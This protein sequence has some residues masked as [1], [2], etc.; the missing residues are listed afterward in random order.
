MPTVH[1]VSEVNLDLDKVLDGV[2]QLDLVE[3]EQFAFEVNN[4]VARR[5][6]PNL[7]QRQVEL[8]QQ[9]N[10]GL[11]V[12]L[13]QRYEELNAKLLDETLTTEEQQELSGLVDQIEQFD[14]K[15]LKHLIEL[16]QLRSVTLD[17]VMDQLGIRRP[18]YA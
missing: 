15:R 5:K 18:R 2:A 6:A 10:K 16:A 13:R 9:I 14:V 12:A 8:L 3:L 4:L 17:T 1:L 11:P 7:P